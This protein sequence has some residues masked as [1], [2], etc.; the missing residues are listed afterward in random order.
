M[1]DYISPFADGEPES[2]EDF[3]ENIGN[4]GDKDD[5]YIYQDNNT[6]VPA[7]VAA[8]ELHTQLVPAILLFICILGLVGNGMVVYVIVHYVTIR[9][10]TYLY[11]MN[12]A[13]VNILYLLA[14]A[15]ITAINYALT[16]WPFGP[17]VCK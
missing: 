8:A 9:K 11:L 17:F 15:P 13:V 1:N 3:N 6:D 5:F 4:S 10:V 7:A 16:D 12:L 2:F 14:S